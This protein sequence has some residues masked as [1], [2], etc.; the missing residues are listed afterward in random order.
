MNS[1]TSFCTSLHSDLLIISF[2]SELHNSVTL[3]D[4]VEK[5]KKRRK[6]EKN[7]HIYQ[8]FATNAQVAFVVEATPLA[9]ISW[10]HASHI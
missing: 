2:I 8:P 7:V 1:S 5:E 6:E 4:E 10:V 9:E 3:I